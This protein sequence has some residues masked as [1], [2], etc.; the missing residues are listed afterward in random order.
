MTTETRRPVVQLIADVVNEVTGLLQTELRLVRVEMSE[1]LSKLANV[2]VMIGVA[3]ALIIAGLGIAFLAV[4]EWLVVA[5]LTRE[6]AL[7]L[8]AVAALA[9]GGII[10]MR[11]VANIKETELVPERSLHHMREDIHTIKDHVT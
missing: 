6:W 7:T 3:T 1:K 10:A 5:G 4:T 9:I 2:G 11:G 8:V